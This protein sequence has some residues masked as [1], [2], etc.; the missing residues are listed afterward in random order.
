M[1]QNWQSKNERNENKSNFMYSKKKIGEK[2]SFG[3]FADKNE[4]KTKN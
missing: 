4:N 1:K 2:K 3:Y